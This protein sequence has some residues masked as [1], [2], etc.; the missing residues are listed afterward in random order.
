MN[1]ATDDSTVTTTASSSFVQVGHG[2]GGQPLSLSIHPRHDVIGLDALDPQTTTTATST[3]R[4]HPRDGNRSKEKYTTVHLCAS[5]QA[6]ELADEAER[7]AVD[8]C[9]AA[10]VSGSMQQGHKMAHLRETLQKFVRVLGPQD[11][12]GLITFAQDAR[13]DL[14]LQHMTNRHKETC[15]QVIGKLTTRGCTNISAA[16]GLA[17]QEMRAVEESSS[18][19]AVRSIFLLTDGH[20]NEGICDAAGLTQLCRN[21][22]A[23][24][25]AAAAAPPSEIQIESSRRGFMGWHLRSRTATPSSAPTADSYPSSPVADPAPP[26]PQVPIV[27]DSKALIPITLHTFGYGADHNAGLLQE[28]AK[29]TEGGSYYFVEDDKSVSMAFGDALGGVVSVVAQ[30][31]LVQLQVPPAAAALGVQIVKVHHDQVIAR[32]NGSYYTVTL[33]DF[34]AEESR[35]VV[36]SVKLAVPNKA[37]TNNTPIPHVTAKVLYTDTLH[38]RPVQSATMTASIARPAGPELS[39]ENEH[40]A[41][42]WLRVYSVEQMAAAEAHAGSSNFAAARACLNSVGAA[43]YLQ[44][45]AVQARRDSS[46]VYQ[47]SVAMMDD[48]S[49]G[50]ANYM[51]VGSK[52]AKQALHSHRTQRSTVMTPRSDVPAAAAAAAP[53]QHN[54]SASSDAYSTKYKLSWRKTFDS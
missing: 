19:N 24:S 20:A 22:L 54:Y 37:T 1:N 49:M 16:L 27:Q 52:R 43:Y 28:M 13:I 14:P 42:Q 8:I 40:V 31:A 2:G 12:W 26:V 7:A 47:T 41:S 25:A 17:A 51:A 29:A 44:S 35:D 34:Y 15:L 4:N 10:D 36:L 33:G 9:V 5:I 38:R 48:Y 21:C 46:C 3:T 50:A 39:P 18:P 30:N 32:K 11:R 23:P 45:P 53:D 6:P